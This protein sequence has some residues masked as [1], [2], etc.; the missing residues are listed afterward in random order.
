M[1]K[2]CNTAASLGSSGANSQIIAVCA[3]GHCDHL[4]HHLGRVPCDD[5][6]HLR[7]DVFLLL[8]EQLEA[9]GGEVGLVRAPLEDPHQAAAP[10]AVGHPAMLLHHLKCP[11]IAQQLR[12]VLAQLHLHGRLVGQ[13]PVCLLLQQLFEALA[14]EVVQLVRHEQVHQVAQLELIRY[15]LLLLE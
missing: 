11:A 9:L 14:I 7:A 5:L 4:L 8:P 12:I 13:A 3:R 6:Q 1:N 2:T 10:E 15:I